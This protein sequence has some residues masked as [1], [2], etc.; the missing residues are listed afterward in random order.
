MD[1]DLGRLLVT[2]DL[3]F[4]LYPA[5]DSCTRLL[6]EYVCASRADA[7]IIAGDI[8]DADTD[9]FSA[10]LNLFAGFP[11]MKLLV[12]GNHDLWTAGTGSEKK[13]REVLPALAADCG[14]RMLDAG[15]VSI[16]AVG[17]IGNIG[18]YDYTFRNRDLRVTLEQYREKRLPGV[19][20]W[21]DGRFIDWDISDEEFTEK[22]LRKLEAAYRSVEP[23][24]HTVV[25]VLHSL[26][27][28][29][30]LHGPQS[31]AHEFCRAYLGSERLGELL[32]GFRKVRYVFCG[33]RHAPEQIRVNHIQAFVVGS[34]YLVKR[35]V[36]L[37]L[38]TGQ[39]AVRRFE[40]LPASREKTDLL[41]P[42]E[43]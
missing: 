36:E 30:L 11:G 10:C 41:P 5:G 28:R 38:T 29:G 42:T 24:V 27:F 8:A 37:D 31:A 7:L 40:P 26:P 2:S 3:H 13:Y 43:A 14:F 32:K 4:G 18:W 22:C 12:P 23:R 9:S 33:H 15:P 35:L 6:A 16:G 25:A 20:T 21:N 34:E 1:R 39:C 19:C 17:I